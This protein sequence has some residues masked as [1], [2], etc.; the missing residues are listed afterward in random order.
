MTAAAAKPPERGGQKLVAPSFAAVVGRSNDEI[1]VTLGVVSTFRGRFSAGRPSMEA[2]QKF[3]VMLGLKGHCSVGLLDEKHVLIRPVVDDDYTR[4]FAR[5][6]WFIGKSPMSIS[7]WS[8]DFR[9]GQELSIAPVWV[10]FPGLPIP[11]FQRNQLMQLASTLGHPLKLDA[12]TGDLRRPSAARVLVEVDISLPLAKRIWIGDEE[13]GFWQP[14]D[15][16]NIPPYCSFCSKFG[17]QQDS[18]FRR[19]PSLR[20]VKVGRASLKLQEVSAPVT[21]LDKGK[22]KQGEPGIPAASSGSVGAEVAG[23]SAPVQK[24]LLLQGHGVATSCVLSSREA[25]V[26]EVPVEAAAGQ[27]IGEV[28]VEVDTTSDPVKVLEDE[29]MEQDMGQAPTVVDDAHQDV[30]CGGVQDVGMQQEQLGDVELGGSLEIIL[31]HAAETV[32]SSSDEEALSVG[33]LSPRFA[34][35]LVRIQDATIVSTAGVID[36][37]VAAL[38]NKQKGLFWNVRGISKAPKL[39]RIK[40]L[41]QMNNLQFL[42]FC[43]PWLE[44]D[45]VEQ[46]RHKLGFHGVVHNV[47]GS[48]WVFFQEPFSGLVVGESPQHVSVRLSHDHVP[49]SHLVVSFVHARCTPVERC[50]LWEGLM[51]DNPGSAAWLVGGDFNVILDAEEKKGG[52]AFN[53][54]EAMEFRQFIN[55]AN[56]MDAGF[57]GAQFTWCNNRHGRARIWKRLDRVL[58]NE[59]YSDTGMSLAVSHLARE[60]SDHAPLLLSVSTR[61]DTKPRS[62][63]FLNVWTRHED[64]LPMVQDSWEQPCV[65]PPLQVLCCKL[66]RLR[67]TIRDWSRRVFGDIFQTVRQKEEEV[68]LAE[69]RVESDDSDAAR[70]HLHLAKGQ[71]RAALRVEELFWK[72]KARVRWLQEGDRN[73]RFFHSVVKNRR[74][75]SIIHRIRNGQGEWVESDDGIGAE[76]IRYFEGLFTDQ[77]PASSSELLQHIPTILTDEENDL[78]EQ[79]PSAVEIR[80]AVFA[81]D[82]ESAPGPDG[83]TG[84]FFTVAWS[85]VGAD[86]VSA[87]CSF[88]C[89]AE[90]PRAITAT[91]IA[92]I[93]K[94]GHPQDFSQFR[95]ISLCNFVN[96]LISRILA[97]RLARILPRIISPQQSGFVRGRL[98]SDNFLLAQELLSNIGRTSRN[99]DVALKLDMSKAYD[100]V[101]W[102]FLTMV[103][104]RFGF[105]EQWIDR[106]W[107]LVSNVWFSV[108]ING[109]SVGFFKST[110]GLRQGD[111]LSPGLFII[112]AE[113]LSRSLNQLVEH[114]EFKCFSVPRGCPMITHLS[115][116]DDVLVFSGASSASLRCV[117]QIIGKYEAVSGQ[118]INVQKS[119]FMVHAKLPSQCVARIRRVTGFGLKSFPV[120]YLGCPLFVGRRKCLYFMELVQSVISKVSSWRSRFLSN[121]GRIVLIKHVLSAIPTH[122]LAASC[123]PK[124]VLALVER[125]MANFL[126]GEREGGLR[127]HWIKWADLCADSSQ[128]GVGVRS[129]LDVH[130][131]FSFKLWWRFRTGECLWATFM[132]AKYCRQSHPCMVAAGQGSS[133]MWRRL[134]QIREVAEQN[135][136]WEMRSGQ[137]NFWFDNWMGS[138]PLCQ[139]LQSVS[140]HLVRDFVLN[141][142]WN[143][144][145]L[146]LWVPDDIVSEIVTKVAP[147]GSADDRA[148]W[149]LTESGDFSI[150][151][152]Y[153]LL[154][155]QTPSSFMFDRVWHPVI[156]IK[157]SFFMVRL[158]RDRLPLA[159][160]LGRLQVYGPSKCF[161]CLASQSESLDHVFAEGELALFLW[162]FFGNSA[163]VSYRGMGVRSRL[164]AWWCQPV[165]H[166][167]LESL[168]SVLPCIICWHIW[169]AR[170]LAIFEGQLLHRQTICDRILADVV[171]LFSRKF[172]GEFFGV[173]SW[174]TVLSIFS[175]WRPRY[176]HRVVCW[177]FPVQGAFKLNTDG[178]SLGNPGVSGGGG[179]LRDSSGALLFGFSVPFGELTCLQ[180]EIKA[181]VFGV[182]QCRLRGFSRIRVEVDSLVLVNLL[183]RQVRC[184]WSVRSDLESLR[185]VQ[186]LEWTVGHCYREMNQ[187]ADALAK[188]GAHSEGTILYTT[189]SELPRVARGALGL[190]RSQIPAIRTRAISH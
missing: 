107:R 11:F 78:L 123:P 50:E 126:W 158:L 16:E 52:R 48:I 121:G 103:L 129:L 133:Y 15:F 60:S 76:A 67:G 118:E 22:A 100:R 68:R 187:V 56:L 130:T 21:S 94:V 96:K 99:A 36:N 42:A 139:R 189:Q 85:V 132:R 190:D 155:S 55:E 77:R 13:Y 66:K 146:R 3:F 18:C 182:Q 167:R 177:E 33:S 156:P 95:P 104:R 84:K 4:L 2:I 131:A 45:K 83:Y 38:R 171:G 183:V 54:G 184:P 7:K 170:N 105:R 59:G 61:L 10:S 35:E 72:Q 116:A 145:L 135:L 161:C 24:Q 88:F 74:V 39:R 168:H 57:S 169:L 117:M 150:A 148:V 79:F 43:E 41:I 166:S 81:M 165:R 20:P 102:M 93:P 49:G 46:Y 62:F 63:R 152:T 69:V 97:D 108:L 181:L 40:K 153:V 32:E 115:Y 119:G 174:S 29:G 6:V 160:S 37:S 128:G 185:A 159:S 120:R 80:N 27:Q 17:H 172:A 162:T 110:R 143:Q 23:L 157:I 113:V 125:A 73:T 51:R 34:M 90:L 28:E 89:G 9:S 92:L 124:G 151:S 112:G 149:A 91:S 137:C 30:G 8:I 154:G 47:V 163:G 101:S 26:L 164:A 142:R 87:V 31:P 82:G 173:G 176:S 180:A 58:V 75:R 65:G 144:Q 136:W 12:A 122:L 64:F 188:V 44:V 147:V 175:G 106:I 1:G 111:P 71:L 178:C 86:V 134:L 14:V 5:R 141:G 179:V 114:R 140:D 53:P 186:G 138:G 25:A 70:V 19:D 98:I 109:A 127:H